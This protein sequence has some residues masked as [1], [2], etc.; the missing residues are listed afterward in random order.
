MIERPH[1]LEPG[2]LRVR[3]PLDLHAQLCITRIDAPLSALV[4][5]TM[6]ARF[7]TSKP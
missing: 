2:W 3:I 7:R 5:A 6:R 4:V 1:H